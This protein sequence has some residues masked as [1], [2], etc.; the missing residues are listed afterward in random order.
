MLETEV[1]GKY[2]LREEQVEK[3]MAKGSIRNKCMQDKD[4]SSALLSRDYKDPKVIKINSDYHNSITGAIGRQ[5]S[6]KEY[7]TSVKKV[8]IALMELTKGVSDAQRIYD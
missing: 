7:I 5:G 4:V 6:S 1:D 8:N 3:I 2:F